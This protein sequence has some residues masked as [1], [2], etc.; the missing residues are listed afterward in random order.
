MFSK[1][2]DLLNLCFVFLSTP[3]V[4]GGEAQL[5]LTCVGSYVLKSQFKISVFI[6][7]CFKSKLVTWTPNVSATCSTDLVPLN[8][9]SN[10]IIY[11]YTYKTIVLSFNA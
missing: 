6:S 9:Y 11:K 4:H 8:N 3:C 7:A 1:R 5:P 2:F 10:S